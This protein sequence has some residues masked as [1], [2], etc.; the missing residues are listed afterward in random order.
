[1]AEQEVRQLKAIMFTDMVGYSARMG[2]DEERTVRLLNEH[3]L[4]VREILPAHG[5]TEHETIGDAFVILFDSAVNAVQCAVQIQKALRDRNEGQPEPEQ[6]WIRI[7]I[8][9][10]DI[11]LR[12]GDIFGDG[13][14]IAAR[15][16]PM[17]D[18]GGICI[19]QD[20]YLQVQK[21][22][23][24]RAVSIGMRELKNIE[25]APELYRI[26][27]GGD[28]DQAVSGDAWPTPP[29]WKKVLWY[30]VTVPLAVLVTLVIVFSPDV[31]SIVLGAFGLPRD[32]PTWVGYV[33]VIAI[34][35]GITWTSVVASRYWRR[36][37][38]SAWL[39]GPGF[40][41]F[42]A[43]GLL[44]IAYHYVTLRSRV[45][46]YLVSAH[47]YSPITP[48]QAQQSRSM[49]LE[50]LTAYLNTTALD[51]LLLGA[52][53]MMVV[54]STLFVPRPGSR[55]SGSRLAWLLLPG[56]ILMFVGLM[57]TWPWVA[58][59]GLWGG[60]VILF[61]LIAS[62]AVLRT[63]EAR[64]GSIW[65]A[66]QAIRSGLLCCVAF[67]GAG[68]VVGY[69]QMFQFMDTWDPEIR[70]AF[71]QRATAIVYHGMASWWIM[72]VPLM[73]VLW[74][75]RRSSLPLARP[76]RSLL[77]QLTW[78]AAAILMTMIP[79]GAGYAGAS[80]FEKLHLPGLLVRMHPVTTGQTPYYLDRKPQTLE[81]G[82][83]LYLAL[84]QRGYDSYSDETLLEAL[85]GGGECGDALKGAIE[86]EQEAT[87]A[88]CVT[89]IEARLYC[90]SLGLRLPTPEEWD[91]GLSDP[92]EPFERGPFAE[93]TMRM[94]H[95][96]PT[97]EVRG[98]T[99]QNGASPDLKPD[100]YSDRVG[101]R[102][103]FTFEGDP[104][105]EIRP[106]TVKKYGSQDPQ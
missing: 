80:M 5:G 40:I 68:V 25:N 62:S 1:M 13:V 51:M 15:V 61:W 34:T 45:D 37:E 59:G 21:R 92:E 76:G 12:G 11:V 96:T 46:S 57:F 47:S 28:E 98:A 87:Y 88:V 91:A 100:A 29:L 49:I 41:V 36:G 56:G 67:S 39:H 35:C 84:T 18:P 101:F 95:G 75:L 82:Y 50:S 17:A 63:R 31:A 52:L 70:R 10:G 83:D 90:E 103:A 86:S 81:Y 73:V 58:N 9:L 53:A 43:A 94:T 48:A 85:A 79:L 64:L 54:M 78:S 93:W 72:L 97:F 89:A 105:G 4:I 74:L 32:L 44:L 99:T 27:L 55:P 16:E 106:E 65:P 24:V 8:H 71:L 66:W 3:R 102:C 104:I 30:A 77:P 26:L 38:P 2:E 22:V 23:G 14:N 69:L 19:T 7:G 60:N 33:L 20:V 6:I 42:P